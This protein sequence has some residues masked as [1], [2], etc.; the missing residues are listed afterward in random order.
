MN[1]YLHLEYF[2]AILQYKNP[3]VKIQM[4]STCTDTNEKCTGMESVALVQVMFGLQQHIFWH[5]RKSNWNEGRH[6]M[7]LMYLEVFSAAAYVHLVPSVNLAFSIVCLILWTSRRNCV[8]LTSGQEA[9]VGQ[10]IL[11][12][13]PVGQLIVFTLGVEYW[14]YLVHNF[15]S[16]WG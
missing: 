14:S 15:D 3:Q 2:N 1:K 9:V 6:F 16:F 11:L 10:H 7:S 4:I 5:V 8:R 13:Y 12:L